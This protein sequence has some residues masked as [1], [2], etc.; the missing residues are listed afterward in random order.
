MLF[1]HCYLYF[2]KENHAH[3]IMF[4]SFILGMRSLRV[5]CVKHDSRGTQTGVPP[6]HRSRLPFLQLEKMPGN[7]IRIS[8]LV[9]VPLRA[10]RHLCGR[11]QTG[12]GEA[13]TLS[14]SPDPFTHP[15]Q[16][17]YRVRAGSRATCWGH[18]GREDVGTPFNSCGW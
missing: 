7:L 16:R 9:T 15:F 10:A 13:R 11:A 5:R 3:R 14:L 1:L 6:T 12:L 17:Y 2:K 8:L 4:T 18:G